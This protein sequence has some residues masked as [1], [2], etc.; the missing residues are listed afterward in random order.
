MPA[1]KTR[2]DSL[3]IHLTG[4]ASDGAAQSDPN[5]SLGNYRSSTEVQALSATAPVNVTG[6]TIDA[7]AGQNGTGTGTLTYTAAGTLL[8]WTA[9][10][11]SIGTGVNVGSN[12]TYIIED[13]G[14]TTKYVRVTVVS[15]SLPGGNQTDSITLS[16]V[17]NKQFDNVSASEASAGDI[18]Y[19]GLMIQNQNAAQIDGVK[20]YISKRGI[21]NTATSGG[22]SNAGAVTVSVTSTTGFPDSGF[23][24]N[25]TSAEKLYYASKTATT[26]VVPAGGRAQFGTSA[27]TGNTS[28]VI[29]YCPPFEIGVEA[30][31]SSHIQTIAN[32]STAPTA[33]S[34]SQPT[35]VG[36]AINIGNLAANGMYGIWLK[37]TVAAGSASIT[38]LA[39][40]LMF[41]YGAA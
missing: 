38:T 15:A 23:I 29:Q 39:R 6:V 33:I 10:S 28:D 32:E 2:S 21:S 35:D 1:Q 27:A 30:T 20:A 16:D 41:E 36:S 22:Y 5:A 12:G 25:S 9:P 3:R 14:D 40:D 24:Y 37:R 31:S 34:F 4:A 26:F 17:Y 7:A 13:G 11:G 18:E 8:Q 19:R